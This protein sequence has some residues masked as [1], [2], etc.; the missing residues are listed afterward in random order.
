MVRSCLARL[1]APDHPLLHG[2]TGR[3]AVTRD[4]SLA[5]LREELWRVQRQLGRLASARMV[6][7]LSQSEEESYNVLAAREL[8]M[9]AE[10]ADA[11]DVILDV[12]L[13]EANAT[14]VE[15]SSDS[16]GARF[17]R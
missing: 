14:S 2:Q 1:T 13:T 7:L 11:I 6:H 4:D 5:E 8:A 15:D 10:L 3:R 12:D 17:Q 16:A 9:I